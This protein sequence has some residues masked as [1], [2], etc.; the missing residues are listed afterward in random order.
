MTTSRVDE[1][2]VREAAQFGL[3]FGCESCAHFAPETARCG[4]GYPTAPHLRIDLTRVA[5]L[6]FCKE[7]ELG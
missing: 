4:N 6:E 2:L 5:G 3:R 7:F 1:Q